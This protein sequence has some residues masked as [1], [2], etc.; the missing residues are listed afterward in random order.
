MSHSVVDASSAEP[1]PQSAPPLINGRAVQSAAT[2]TTSKRRGFGRV[3]S[4]AVGSIGPT[5][6]LLGFAAIFYYGH[7]N[8]WRIPKFAAITGTQ[9]TIVDD[10]C[11]DHAVPE[12][13]CVEC[14]P[15]L[16]PK[17][18]DYGWCSE[19][20]VH[21]CVLHHPDLAQLKEPPSTEQLSQDLRRATQALALVSRPEN[22]SSCEV[23]K[24]RIQFESVEAVRQAGVDVELVERKPI[25][26][27]ITGNGEIVYD[28]TRQA[29]LASRVPGSV[30]TVNKQIGDPVTKGEV[31]AI[32]DAAKV[33]DLKTSLL[34]SLAEEKLQR[35]NVS[36]LTTA[37]NAIAGSRIL[38]AEAALAKAQADVLSAEQSLRNLGLP[39]QVESLRQMSE[40]QILDR[41][42]L[43]GIPDSVRSQIEPQTLSAN[44]LPTVSPM[45]GIV[46]KRSVTTGE[47]VDPTRILFQVADTSRMWLRLS[48]PL[49]NMDQ[50]AI[51][52][53][54][55]FTPDGSRREI[56]GRLDWISTSVDMATRM[57]EV[58][59]VLEN[60]SGRL[61]NETFGTGK[62][63]LRE[64]SEAIVVPTSALHWEGCCQVIFV[65][66]KGY[67][68]SPESHKVFHLRSVRA[69][70]SNDGYT[71][72]IVGLLPGEVVVTEGSDVL[73]SQL[74]KN[75][76]GAGC[77]AE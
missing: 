13:I 1:R 51:G 54:I 71:E 34:R 3:L 63:I 11:E 5:I 73:R 48:V 43:L 14:D 26:E 39:V 67:F 16:M 19:H 52:Q 38:D 69:G 50:L 77:C 76:L 21:N 35:Q 42:R 72:I 29:S 36:R 74:L 57:L 55:R 4:L 18:Q 64:E 75:S 68:E 28:P 17:G 10:W 31:L 46:I 70:V 56:E 45:N 59:A 37:R 62:V 32:V 47:V 44:L 20:G 66:D 61:R 40:Q 25:V 41:L 9:E 60:P 6:V 30:W 49:E 53:T 27:S 12:S 15:T 8:D 2:Q 33:G 58:R 23:H 65:R 22:N 24:A 7:H